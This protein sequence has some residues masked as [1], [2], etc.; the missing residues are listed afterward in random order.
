MRI[1]MIGLAPNLGECSVDYVG[2]PA[3]RQEA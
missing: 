3:S 2:F 1:Q